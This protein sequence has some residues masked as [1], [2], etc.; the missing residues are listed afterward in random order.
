MIAVGMGKGQIY[1]LEGA[2]GR[3]R[4]KFEGR[5]EGVFSVAFSPCGVLMASVGADCAPLIWDVTGLIRNAGRPVE[6]LG[7]GPLNALWDDLRRE[8]AAKAWQAICALAAR[9]AQAVP[10]LK[11]RLAER[12]AR[13]EPK[14]LAMLLADL[15]SDAFANRDAASQQLAALGPVVVPALDKFCAV[16]ASAEARRRAH[17]VLKQIAKAGLVTEALLQARAVEV[18]EYAGTPPAR[19]LLES[20]AQVESASPQSTRARAALA[21]LARRPTP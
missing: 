15:D 2:T 7:V 8:D 18:L 10:L 14:R 6:P 5:V 13:L 1:L 11:D 16:A 9:P 4:A 19:E 3:E 21:R 17:D 12:S 20:A